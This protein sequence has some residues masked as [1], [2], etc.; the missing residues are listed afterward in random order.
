MLRSFI[1]L[2][3]YF[4]VIEN[5]L[6]VIVF[7]LSFFHELPHGLLPVYGRIVHDLRDMKD[8]HPHIRY[9]PFLAAEL[10]QPFVY[11]DQPFIQLGLFLFEGVY[12]L[13]FQ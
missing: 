13:T 2:V 3:S 12:I 7:E 1:V 8:I 4:S 11:R 9:D 5:L 6:V 10:P